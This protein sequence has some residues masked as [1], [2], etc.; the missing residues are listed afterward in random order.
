MGWSPSAKQAEFLKSSTYELLYG[1]ANGGGKTEALIVDACGMQQRRN[2]RVT[3]AIDHPMYRALLLR[4]YATDLDQLADR[5]ERMYT[6][7][8][9]AVKFNR[10]KHIFTFP[11]GASITLSHADSVDAIRN[12]YKGDE[13]QYLGWEELTEHPVEDGYTYLLTRLRGPPEL[14]KF[15]RATTNPDGPGNDWVKERWRIPDNGESVAPFKVAADGRLR[16]FIRAR[17]YD[18]PFIDPTYA[19]TLGAQSENRRRALLE[20]H[21]DIIDLAGRIY[22]RQYEKASQ[23]GRITEVP[24]ETRSPVNTFWDIGGSDSTAIWFH[25]KI[26]LQN[27]FIDYVEADHEPL[28]FYARILREKERE[29]GYNY[30]M[31]YIPHDAGWRRQGMYENQT[32]EELMNELGLEPTQLVERVDDVWN[33]IELTRQAWASCWFDKLRCKQGLKALRMYRYKITAETGVAMR[34]PLHD[35]SSHGADAFRQFAQ[36]FAAMKPSFMEHALRDDD[37][38]H[39]Y[40][41]DPKVSR[42]RR[43]KLTNPDDSWVV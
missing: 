30:A 20:G 37:E 2:G 41:R 32:A 6:M 15:V 26:G 14:P 23:Q 1:G 22:A 39:G 42:G 43:N 11:S 9:P 28:D 36:G 3:N 12:K 7:F 33:G 19:D 18:N 29:H 24:H 13:Y 10:S 4:R 17:V 16:E 34:R 25:Q 35:W 40:T 31:H 8:C 27:R 5:C 21:W 38:V